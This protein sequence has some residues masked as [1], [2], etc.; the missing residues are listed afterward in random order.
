MAGN[1]ELFK[2]N[3]S[4]PSKFAKAR[5]F[6]TIKW[7][8]EKQY[9]E[10]IVGRN[11]TL[12]KIA[13]RNPDAFNVPMLDVA[14]SGLSLSPRLSHAY[15]VPYGDEVTFTPGYRGLIHLA[16]K[17]KTLK[18]VQCGI[19][20]E[21]EQFRVWTDETGKHLIHDEN[22]V[23]KSNAEVVAA[24]C[25]A[26]FNNGGRHI[27]IMDANQLAAVEKHALSRKGGGAVWRG[28]WKDQMQIKAVIRRASKFW[29]IDDGGLMEHMLSVMDK[30][31]PAFK[32][33]AEE[34]PEQ[35]VCVSDEQQMEL[36]QAL[37]DGPDGLDGPAANK[38]LKRKA[39]AMGL[40]SADNI[41]ADQFD[42][43]K[44]DLLEHLAEYRKTNPATGA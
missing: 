31:D 44:A 16:F 8:A 9:L 27:E 20:Y 3:K 28:P 23:K 17:A 38:W 4:L 37:C 35:Y 15:L 13:T 12:T 39:N 40:T 30:Y 2:K 5:V 33:E 43:V 22:P 14:F 29:P 42:A 1:I 7:S 6:D 24:Y 11:S 25:I 26:Q 34:P 36:V 19:V 18:E 21:G 41:P 10:Q 32:D